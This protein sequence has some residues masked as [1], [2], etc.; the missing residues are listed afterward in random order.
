MS[1]NNKEL[2]CPHC[3]QPSAGV[4]GALR[5]VTKDKMILYCVVCKKESTHEVI[6]N[7]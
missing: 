4:I 6:P 2:L 1:K 7:D 3:K 5:M